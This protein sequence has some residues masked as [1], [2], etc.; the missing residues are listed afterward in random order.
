MVDTTYYDKSL[1]RKLLHYFKDAPDG[2]AFPSFNYDLIIMET[3]VFGVRPILLN[4]FS[5]YF[6]FMYFCTRHLLFPPLM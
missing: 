4:Y 2:T 3:A 6:C 5:V 1:W